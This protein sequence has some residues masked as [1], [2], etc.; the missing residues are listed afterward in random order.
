M[1]VFDPTIDHLPF[2]PVTQLTITNAYIASDSEAPHVVFENLICL[3]D[4][5]ASVTVIPTEFLDP[6]VRD[7]RT[8][9]YAIMGIRCAPFLVL[10]RF[11]GIHF[12]LQSIIRFQPHAAMPHCPSAGP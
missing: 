12:P 6:A 3:W 2:I 9:G 1:L 7:N 5:G 4:T 8:E 11:P 10:I